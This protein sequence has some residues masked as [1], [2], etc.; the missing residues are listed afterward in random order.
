MSERDEFEAW[1]YS[2]RQS[3]RNLPKADMWQA[4]QA[5]A[6]RATPQQAVP[7]LTDDQEQAMFTMSQ[8]RNYAHS[9]HNTRSRHVSMEIYQVVCSPSGERWQ[10]VTRREFDRTKEK[11]RR[12]VYAA[13]PQP[14]Q[15]QEKAPQRY[16][17]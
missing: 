17:D 14:S 10:D 5:R 4:W 12:I 16:Q 7:A 3:G 15:E 6:A 8:M 9:Y 13:S 1:F 2:Q 11:L